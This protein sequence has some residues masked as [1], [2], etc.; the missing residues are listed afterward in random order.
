VTLFAFDAGHSAGTFGKRWTWRSPRSWRRRSGP[1][2]F[3]LEKIERV[4]A[5]SLSSVSLFRHRL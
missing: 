2:V 1:I 4:I 3:F 5:R